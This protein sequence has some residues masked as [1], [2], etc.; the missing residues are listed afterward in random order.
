MRNF[1]SGHGIVKRTLSID[2][3]LLFPAGET[4]TAVTVDE[5]LFEDLDDLDLEDEDEDED[6]DWKPGD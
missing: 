1:I 4:V 3:I 5:S 6:P 2:K